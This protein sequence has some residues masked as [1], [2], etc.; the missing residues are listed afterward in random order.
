MREIT[1]FTHRRPEDT[2][3]IL[4]QVVEEAARAGVTVRFDEEETSKHRL[5]PGPGVEVNAPLKKDVDLC[6]VLGGDGTIL[7][8]LQF[9][10]GSGVAGFAI[11]FGGMGCLGPVEGTEA[12]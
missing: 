5:S 10:A 3:A 12:E 9:S 7:R 6:L 1:V 11:N 2:T 4:E 8:A